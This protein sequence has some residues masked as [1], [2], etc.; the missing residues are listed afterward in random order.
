MIRL[1]DILL[2]DVVNDIEFR[3][4]VKTFEGDPPEDENGNFVTFDDAVFP[5]KPY[6][7]ESGAPRGTLTI[8]WGHTG[9][10]ATAGNTIT[11]EQAEELLTADI[12]EKERIAKAKFSKY[13]TFTTPVQRAIVNI[14][15]RG[16]LGPKTTALIKTSP[17]DWNSV[18]DEYLNSN[19]YRREEKK[20]MER[21]ARTGTKA[22]AV[23]DTN[24][25][26]R[27]NK[28]AERFRSA[29]PSGGRG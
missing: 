2:E 16:N 18:A 13:S 29:A 1:K 12:T 20:S 19:E 6:D 25:Y 11:P 10:Y 8:G 7:P 9:E 5:S 22:L 21:R 3:D 27:M 14:L 23:P 24:I 26:R 28:N 17:V 15:F 4:E